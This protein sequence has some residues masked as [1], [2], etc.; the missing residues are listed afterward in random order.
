MISVYTNDYE[1]LSSHLQGVQLSFSSL[2]AERMKEERIRL[3]L[4]QAS[5][6]GLCGVSREIWGRYERGAAAPGGD[7]LFSFANAGADVQ[8]ILTGK[9]SVN[10]AAQEMNETL[11]DVS[12]LERITE[13]LE[14]AASQAGKRWPVKKL[15]A[16][17][18]EIYNVLSTDRVLDE[19]QVQRVLKLVV[20]R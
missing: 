13:M 16:V 10:A 14:I 19:H 4:K 15:T 5:A 2:S 17:A 8:F 11:I 1:D 18:A 3:G 12:R 7:V 20:N 6:A 9:H